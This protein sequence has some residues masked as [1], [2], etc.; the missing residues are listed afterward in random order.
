MVSA[1]PE[2][3]LYLGAAGDVD[4]NGTVTWRLHGGYMAGTWRVHDVTKRVHGGY[5][6]GKWRVV[7]PIVT[8]AR[9][10]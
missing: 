5:T 3:R 6:A 8:P 1:F 7:D 9:R 2:L 10:S 4:P